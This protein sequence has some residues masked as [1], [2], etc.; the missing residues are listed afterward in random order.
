MAHG[1]RLR[2][3]DAGIRELTD[4]LGK[5]LP[6]RIDSPAEPAVADIGGKAIFDALVPVVYLTQITVDGAEEAVT[7]F[8]RKIKDGDAQMCVTDQAL[9]PANVPT[10][11]IV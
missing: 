11:P 4:A 7:D 10:E 8:V 2:L 5:C 3:T 9:G 6:E 1:D